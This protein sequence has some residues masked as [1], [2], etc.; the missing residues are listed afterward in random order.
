[1]RAEWDRIVGALSAEK[2][3]SSVFGGIIGEAAYHYSEA[4]F[5]ERQDADKQWLPTD[6]SKH[7][8]DRYR[9]KCKT[10][11]KS[12]EE[13][14]A[15]I[16]TLSGIPKRNPAAAEARYHRGEYRKCLTEL[17]LTPSSHTRMKIGGGVAGPEDSFANFSRQSRRGFKAI[18]GGKS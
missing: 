12:D 2:R 11:G 5:W 13:I 17:G 8:V 14:E 4:R 7:Q 16:L 1:M 18:K 9:A 15:G 3:L 10:L 6:P